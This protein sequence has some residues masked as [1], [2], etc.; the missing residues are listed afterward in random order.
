MKLFCESASLIFPCNVEIFFFDIRN[1]QFYPKYVYGTT[2]KNH[3]YL[4]YEIRIERKNVNI[5]RL[6]KTVQEKFSTFQNFD[7]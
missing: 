3:A 2:V 4:L 7:F 5:I 1:T 6:S